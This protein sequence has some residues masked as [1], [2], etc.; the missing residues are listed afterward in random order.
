MPLT[1]RRALGLFLAVVVAHMLEHVAQMAQIHVM[2]L[3]PSQALGLVGGL[4]PWLVT[5]ESLHYALALFTLAGLV[6]L[7]PGTAG[8]A[9]AWWDAAIVIQLWHHFE[10]VLLVMQ[11]VSGHALF[12]ASAPTSVL[13]LFLRR[14]E[15]HMTYNAL[16]F[17]PLAIGA[18]LQLRKPRA[19]VT[20]APGA[21][22]R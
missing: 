10:H 2:G 16:V 3:P 22:P 18:W 20:A 6:L 15:L 5:S 19:P 7:R 17:V 4:W 8:A 11:R 13:Q 14:A 1:R 12:G 21:A 9:R